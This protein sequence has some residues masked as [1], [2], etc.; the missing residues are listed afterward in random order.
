MGSAI[1]YF[2][3]YALQSL[4]ALEAVDDDGNVASAP[5]VEAKRPMQKT[6]DRHI[7]TQER[8]DDAENDVQ[9]E[10]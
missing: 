10:L 4:F 8:K 9:Y 3:R 5:K 6:I 7:E 2:R 1:T